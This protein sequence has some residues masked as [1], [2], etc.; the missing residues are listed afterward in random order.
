MSQWDWNDAPLNAIWRDQARTVNAPLGRFVVRVRRS[1][2]L[3]L[4]LVTP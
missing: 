3:L 2:S 4:T 1:E